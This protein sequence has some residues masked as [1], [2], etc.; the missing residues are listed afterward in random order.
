MK[1][2][3]LDLT[4][5][6]RKY[7]KDYLNAIE[8]VFDDGSFI[9]GNHVESFENEMSAYIGSKSCIGVGN[10]TDA[11]RIAIT[12][13][14]IKRGDEI[15]TT[16]F[17]FIATAETIVQSGGIPVFADIDPRTLNIDAE[18]IEANITDRTKAILPVHLYGNPANMD[19][20]MKIAENNNL[21][22]IEDCA[23]SIGA[24]YKGKKT[25]SIGHC[26]TFSFFPTKNL[27]CPGDGGAVSTSDD[28]IEH[29]VRV[30][31]KHGAV[32]KYTHHFEGF[33]S[34]LDAVHAA[35]LSV[36]L[37]LIDD[38]NKR[39]RAIADRYRK[40]INAPV[41]Y[42]QVTEN[43]Y[44]I[45]HQF[46]VITEQRDELRSYLTKQGIGT[47]I[48][49]PI[50]LHKQRVFSS[51]AEEKYPVAEKASKQVLS[52]PVYPELTDDEVDYVSDRINDF[53]RK[54]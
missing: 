51:Y 41:Q 25:G 45:Y 53:F 40:Q 21:T 24:I 52:L 1:I 23:Q 50:P 9:L 44:H 39:R 16:P 13:A 11:L 10:G 17:T 33:N 12:A 15:I 14:D 38:K 31:R 8:S 46:T 18:S 27:G 3:I 32:K 49:Y 36:K 2:K 4:R 34:R 29:M 22:V 30:L 35:V 5:E 42:Q 47:A 48:H 20:I 26:G 43:A 6:Y 28:N 37:K 54:H 19:D 7:R